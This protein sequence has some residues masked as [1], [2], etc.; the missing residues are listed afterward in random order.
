MATWGEGQL[1]RYAIE[2]SH[3]LAAKTSPVWLTTFPAPTFPPPSISNLRFILVLKKKKKKV[4]WCTCP[5]HHLDGG[6]ESGSSETTSAS[7]KPAWA[8]ET[9]SQNIERQTDRQIDVGNW[10]N[11]DTWSCYIS[12]IGLRLSV[13]LLPQAPK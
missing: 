10:F 12:Q 8:T 5:F 3:A 7:L 9:L 2:R 1:P 13:I 4:W 11:F 6:R